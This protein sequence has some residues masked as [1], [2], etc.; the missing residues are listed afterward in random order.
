MLLTPTYHVFHMYKPFRGATALPVEFSTT[1]QTGNVET[2]LLSTS[3]AR[4]T[5]G[6]LHIALANI[7]PRE[8]QHV[9]VTVTGKVPRSF[10]GQILTAAAMDAH[11]T[12]DKPETVKPAVF[13]GAEVHEGAIRVDVPA[14]SIIVLSET[15]K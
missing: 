6:R 5:D 9:T 1:S 12:F 10:T 2:V 11:N 8:T 14:K 13:R 3:A 15:G 7:D 4:G